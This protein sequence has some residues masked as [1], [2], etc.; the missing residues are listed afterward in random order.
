MKWLLALAATF[1]AWRIDYRKRHTP[2]HPQFRIRGDC[3]DIIWYQNK[4]C[5]ILPERDWKVCFTFSSL[6]QMD[7]CPFLCKIA[8][9]RDLPDKYFGVA[10]PYRAGQ[11]EEIIEWAT[12]FESPQLFTYRGQ[13]VENLSSRTPSQEQEPTH[14]DCLV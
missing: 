2:L 11:L 1:A 9:H 7:D 14:E 10:Y 6:G 3:G 8:L 5:G 13:F 4:D 12:R